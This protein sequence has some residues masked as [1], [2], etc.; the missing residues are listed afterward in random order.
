ML[1]FSVACVSDA[2]AV[3]CTGFVDCATGTAVTLKSVAVAIT[4][5]GNALISI[6]KNPFHI[7]YFLRK[8]SVNHVF[9]LY[10]IYAYRI[11]IN[12]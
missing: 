11:T 9:S 3:C 10:M 2:C 12:C 7:L 6:Q 1:T 5:T 8:K 4:L